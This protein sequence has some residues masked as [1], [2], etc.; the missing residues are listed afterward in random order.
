MKGSTLASAVGLVFLFVHGI[1][2]L[3]PFMESVSHKGTSSRSR[4]NAPGCSGKQGANQP[5][6]GR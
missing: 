1:L 6:A 3:C 5:P 2:V 4:R